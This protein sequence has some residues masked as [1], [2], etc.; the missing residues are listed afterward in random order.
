MKVRRGSER[1]ITYGESHQKELT[2]YQ[3]GC[4][5][6]PAVRRGRRAHLTSSPCMSFPQ[7]SHRDASWRR[8]PRPAGS[9]FENPTGALGTF[10]HSC[11]PLPTLE[12]AC[13]KLSIVK[14]RPQLDNR[15][16]SFPVTGGRR[17]TSLAAMTASSTPAIAETSRSAEDHRG[18][19][20]LRAIWR[21]AAEWVEHA[22]DQAIRLLGSAAWRPAPAR[23]M[24]LPR[25]RQRASAGVFPRTSTAARTPCASRS[26]GPVP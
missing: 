6:P 3:T 22:H 15:A 17:S 13:Q 18:S 14:R 12:R 25:P 8:S 23:R 11:K 9:C 21:T 10:A 24:A 26:A 4:M 5:I 16:Q 20:P 1:T 19:G 7:S 2:H